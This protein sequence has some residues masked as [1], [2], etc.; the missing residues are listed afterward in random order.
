MFKIAFLSKCIK[1]DLQYVTTELGIQDAENLR[2]I[3]LK[4]AIVANDEY[5]GIF[6]KV[7]L[8]PVIEDRKMKENCIKIKSI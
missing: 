4:N 1:Q 2:I 3:K 6:V 8:N 5:E 7:Y